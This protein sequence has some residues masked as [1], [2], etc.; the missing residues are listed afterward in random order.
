M[1]ADTYRSVS[2]E[3]VRENVYR[4][5]NQAGAALT[6]GRDEGLLSPVDLLLA[7]IGA[8]TAIDV[9]TVTT[10]RAEPDTFQVLVEGDKVRDETGSRMTDLTVTFRLVFPEGEAGDAARAVA[11]RALRTSHDRT[12]T[13]SRTIE[14]GSPVTAILEERDATQR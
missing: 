4:A 13:V 10:R 6:F 11:P 2:L 9:D 8:C 14:R 7:S 5:T 3:R 1:A 12:C